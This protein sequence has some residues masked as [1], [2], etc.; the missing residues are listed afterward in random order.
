MRAQLSSVR[1]LRRWVRVPDG[2]ALVTRT[3]RQVTSGSEMWTARMRPPRAPY[4]ISPDRG[5]P[6]STASLRRTMRGSC[7]WLMVIAKSSHPP[8]MT[9][10]FGSG[11]KSFLLKDPDPGQDRS[12]DRQ[13]GLGT[14]RLSPGER[15][16]ARQSHPE[17]I[18]NATSVTPVLDLPGSAPLFSCGSTRY[19]PSQR[20]SRRFG[21]CR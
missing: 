12:P 20:R 10:C 11:D 21:K 6:P 8:P 7:T 5:S 14:C 4:E 19:K 2:G 15:R 1:K 9:A 17:Q 13:S 3:N 16:R 18:G